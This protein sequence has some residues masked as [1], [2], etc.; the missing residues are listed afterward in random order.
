M[1]ILSNDSCLVR[2]RNISKHYI[3]HSHKEPIILRLTGVVDDGDDIGSLLSHIDQIPTHPVRKLDCI[4]NSSR[5]DDVG[6]VRDSGPRCT[7]EVEDL[8]SRDDA[9]LRDAANDGGSDLRSVRVPHPVFHFLGVDLHTDAL[10]VVDR[11]PGD[12]VLGHET[13]LSPAGHEH[14]R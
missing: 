1:R 6:N 10:L 14:A 4:D 2:L 3:H 9:G 7:T 8:C 5:A 13:I 12:E 11:L